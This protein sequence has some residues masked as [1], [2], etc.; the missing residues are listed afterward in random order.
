MKQ[1]H[2]ATVQRIFAQPTPQRFG[3]S[4]SMRFLSAFAVVCVIVL[5][6][7]PAAGL[8][9][10]TARNP[11]RSAVQADTLRYAV[12][13]GQPLIV[14]LPAEVRGR[15]ASY[16]L[17]RGPALSWLVDRSFFWRTLSSEHGTM[18]VLIERRAEGREPDI[19]V[20]AIQVGR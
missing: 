6:S 2:T 18:H 11:V 13:A 10:Q 1:S 15:Y 7:P 17:L 5:A 16:R 12:T 14:Q 3:H 20:L 4:A 8:G 9:V 19:L